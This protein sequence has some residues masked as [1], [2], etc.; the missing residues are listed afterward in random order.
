MSVPQWLRTVAGATKDYLNAGVTHVIP[1]WNNDNYLR[2][3]EQL[4][5]ALGA[6]YNKDERLAWVEFSGYGDFSE[7]HVA[8]MRDQ[9]GL[10]GP[11]EQDSVAQL[12]YYSQYQDQYITKA[13]ITRL[14]SANLS[15]FADTQILIAP[16]NPEIVRQTMRDSPLVPTLAHPVGNRSDCLGAYSPVPTWAENQ[17]SHYVQ[18]SDP[19]VQVM[20]NQWKAAPIVTEWCN[21]IPSGTKL[22]YYQKGLSDVVNGHVSVTSST[23]F[24]DQF[25]TTK[26]DATQFSLWANANKFSGYRYAITSASVPNSVSPGAQVPIT[27]GWTNFGSAPTYERWQ[28]SYEVRNSS[29]AAIRNVPSAMGL[30]TLYADQNYS[31]VNADPASKATVDS[32]SIPTTGL[33]PGT[34]SI[35]A[36]VAWNEH[37]SGGTNTVDFAP[38][39]LAQGGRDSSGAYPIG[40]FTIQPVATTTV[41]ATTTPPPTTTTPQPTTT[42]VAPTTT[43]TPPPTTTVIPTTTV[44]VTTTVVPTTTVTPTTP[45]SPLGD[46][47][48]VILRF[49][50]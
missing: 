16:G 30:K 10:P 23:G 35:V 34:Y 32:T 17:Y 29:G 2:Y 21:F 20:N 38:M 24:P 45:K 37:K 47:C 28:V 4:L 9:L 19:L 40:G 7:N 44:P 48:P 5:A 31:S 8:F 46:W 14:V 49:C 43:T 42:T 15:A 3:T 13:S 11:A 50:R 1:D 25:A 6:R 36:R 18:T 22:Q 33:Q 27:I 12:G 26:M 39:A 41:A